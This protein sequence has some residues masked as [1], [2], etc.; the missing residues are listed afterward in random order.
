MQHC[1]NLSL[2][3]F[4]LKGL[5]FTVTLIINTSFTKSI[6]KRITQTT[7]V[8]IYCKRLVKYWLLITANLVPI[9]LYIVAGHSFHI[10]ISTN[11]LSAFTNNCT[12]YQYFG[13][14]LSMR[15]KACNNDW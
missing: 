4:Q 5:S 7:K 2:E 15:N 13:N 14:V 12:Y 10:M 11:D 8:I 6:K 9:H 3:K 1:S